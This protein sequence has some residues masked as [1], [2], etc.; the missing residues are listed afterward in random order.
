MQQVIEGFRLSPQQTRLWLEKRDSAA[1][2]AQCVISI[3]GPLNK[4][5]LKAA[6]VEV[7]NWHEVLRTTYRQLPGVKI[8]VQVIADPIRSYPMN[9]V[10]LRH[11]S[12]VDREAR[13][14][15][16]QQ[17]ERQRAFNLEEGPLLEL[18]LITLSEQRHCLIADL[19]ALFE[20]ECGVKFRLAPEK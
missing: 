2:H 14:K 12:E 9:E 3:V 13:I 11:L 1:Y 4:E 19:P 5:I 16:I 20:E 10:D 15:E 18:H 17:S 8:P 6:L 7:I